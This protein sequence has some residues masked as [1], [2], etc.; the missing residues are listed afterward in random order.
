MSNQDDDKVT[1]IY[2]QIVN[3]LG[4]VTRGKKPECE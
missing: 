1:N 2:T 4:I 3:K